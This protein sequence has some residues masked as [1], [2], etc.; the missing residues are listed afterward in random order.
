MGLLARPPHETFVEIFCVL[1]KSCLVVEKI[2]LDEHKPSRLSPPRPLRAPRLL[3]C[4]TPA[5]NLPSPILD[6]FPFFHEFSLNNC[7]LPRNNLIP[8]I[9]DRIRIL[10]ANAPSSAPLTKQTLI[11]ASRPR[12]MDSTSAQRTA[13]TAGSCSFLCSCFLVQG[14]SQTLGKCR[15]LP[16]LVA[17]DRNYPPPRIPRLQLDA[18]H[19]LHVASCQRFAIHHEK[20]KKR[21]KKE[22]HPPHPHPTSN[23]HELFV[24]DVT[25][26]YSQCQYSKC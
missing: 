24:V 19:T 7:L 18:A 26:L 13:T 6:S 5:S 20:K 23:L 21:K 16:P 1:S 4:S 15:C 10:T 22:S 12:D 3:S 14:A 11:F 25:I 2:R 8:S 17:R 9:E